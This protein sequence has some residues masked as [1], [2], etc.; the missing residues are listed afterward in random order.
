M[1]ASQPSYCS[2]VNCTSLRQFMASIL[3]HL[4]T[5]S[6]LCKTGFPAFLVIKIKVE[7]EMNNSVNLIAK[8]EKLCSAQKAYKFH[9]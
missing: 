1:L 6:H 9:Q 5:M 7:Q 4:L 2:R 8:Y 3:K